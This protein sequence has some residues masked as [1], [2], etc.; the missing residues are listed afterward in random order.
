[1][2]RRIAAAILLT[3]WAILVA[4]GFAAFW[5]TRA[6]LLADLDRSLVECA[7]SL[8]E[9]T[10]DDGADAAGSVAAGDDDRYVIRNDLG[11]TIASPAH[12][13]RPPQAA[14]D[15][16]PPYTATFAPLGGGRRVRTVT[17][18]LSP[19]HTGTPVTVVYS[20]P[21]D[22]L[23]RL[24][25]TLAAV[26]TGCGAAAGAAAAA[27][28][29]AVARSALRPLHAAADVVGVI[30]ERQLDRRIDESSLPPELRPVAARLNGMLERLEHAF[31]QRKRFLADA[32]HELRTPVAALVTTL[33][34]A[35]RR[36]RDAAELTR[37]AESC[38]SE[39]RYLRRLVTTLLEHARGETARSAP[40]PEP[41]DAA[42]LL[43]HCAT[44]AESLGAAQG[45]L[46]VRSYRAPIPVVTELDRLRGIVTNLLAN[47]VEHNRPGGTVE[48]SARRAGRALELSVRDTGPGI[49]A[50]H[51][52]NLFQPFYR[53]HAPR[54][55][56]GGASPGTGTPRSEE[57]HLGLGLFIVDAHLKAL[58]GRCTVESQVGA[59]T[60]FHV[61]IPAA[62]PT[63]SA[64][65][66]ENPEARSQPPNHPPSSLVKPL[67]PAGLNMQAPPAVLHGEGLG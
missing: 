21:T 17:V 65:M 46:V 11:Q 26:L 40:A 41:L 3:V 33:E 52:P 55:R 50:E 31:A 53:T 38:L 10:G 25:G 7:L 19:R 28:A 23:D 1:M 54:R 16:L 45:V 59:G 62:P 12:G 4:G 39:A 15:A 67:A 22:G 48:L 8:P 34:V 63:G 60:T 20:R 66:A 47:A 30:D 29:V 56:S 57:P 35:L 61:S 13:A 24:L 14:P 43:D 42:D 2:T 5:V 9:V 18:R 27:V 37:T 49:A 64:A 36:K 32:S 58:G 51:L 6:V 44:I